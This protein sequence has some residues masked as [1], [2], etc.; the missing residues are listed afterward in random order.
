[1]GNDY[2][3]VSISEKE[4]ISILHNNNNHAHAITQSLLEISPLSGDTYSHKHAQKQTIVTQNE[5]KFFS[6]S[7]EAEVNYY[8]QCTQF[9]FCFPRLFNL[10]SRAAEKKQCNPDFLTMQ[11]FFQSLPI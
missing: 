8:K 2:F 10:D 3:F 6:V 1:M 9:H 5:W 7:R 11:F 4:I